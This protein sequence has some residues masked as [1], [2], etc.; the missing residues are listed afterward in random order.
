MTGF[1][2]IRVSLDDRRLVDRFIR[3][4][5]WVN[6]VVHP[7]DRWVPPLLMDRRDYLDPH[8]NPFFDHAQAAFWLA[9]HGTRDV[10]R[11][12]AVEDADYAAT[13]G[14]RVGHFGMFE[15]ADDEDIAR[16][17]VDRACSWLAE[18]G[19]VRATGPM[20]LSMNYTCG[21]LIDGFAHRPGINMPWNPA[22]Y[23][24]LMEAAGL[25]KAKDLFQW[26][27]DLVRNPLPERVVRIADSIRARER[28]RVRKFDFGNWDA[29]VGET[30]RLLND[31][32]KDNWGFVPMRE[33]EYRHVAKDLKLVLH[34]D[35]GLFAEVDGRPVGFALSILDINPVLAKVD[36][37][38]F[39]TGALRLAWEVFV[40]KSPTI[41]RLLLLGI[42]DGYRRR[43]V[44]A[45]LMAETFRNA[46]RAGLEGGQIGWTLED[47]VLVNRAIEGFGCEKTFTYRIWERA[48]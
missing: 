12:A 46:Q 43:G 4:P 22:Y 42:E 25:V 10:G 31:A 15:C 6:R 14:E 18:R 3:V 47:N 24:R 20:D 27:I 35:L 39:P 32:W 23:R 16:A 40:R 44:D 11:I 38:L 1:Q 13:H 26:S 48:L 5:W 30:L 29:E 34:R 7:N 37:R 28:I 19:C 33:N 36:G 17:L 9:C 2:L 21:T 41:G 45:L 8:R